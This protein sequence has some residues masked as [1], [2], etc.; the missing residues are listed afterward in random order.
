MPV[1]FTSPCL[2]GNSVPLRAH[3][4]QVDLAYRRLS[5]KS[6]YVGT[7]PQESAAPFGKPL[8]ININSLD[9]SVN[10]GVTDR[11]ALTLTLPFS[12]GTHSRFYGDGKRHQVA[13]AGLGDISTVATLWLLNPHKHEDANLALG[14]GVK[15]PSGS[16]AVTDDFFLADGSVIQ[17]AVDQSIQLGDGGWGLIMQM[18][19]YRKLFRRTSGYVN[20]A[21]LMSPE[22]QT[23]VKSPYPGVTLSIPDVYSARA[24]IAYAV[25]PKRG[26]SASLGIRVDGIPIRD[27]VGDSDGFRRPGYSLYIDPGVAFGHGRNTFTLNVPVRVHQNFERSLVDVQLGKNGGGDLAKYLI[28]VGYSVRF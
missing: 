8:F 25:Q 28:F 6:W 4:W 27:L 10:Y 11:F 7:E 22:D 23:D 21:Y 14:V 5:A 18:Q 26:L 16:N 15:T 1:R 2:G 9:V 3:H 13:A 19:G 17:S 20:G 12:G 24:G